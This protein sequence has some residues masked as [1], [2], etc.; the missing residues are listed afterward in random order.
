MGWQPWH[1]CTC[2]PKP[3]KFNYANPI[4]RSQPKNPISASD[5]RLFWLFFVFLLF[6]FVLT[7]F[8]HCGSGGGNHE[9]LF[10]IGAKRKRM[11]SLWSHI[12]FA[13]VLL[14]KRKEIE[15]DRERRGRKGEIWN[16]DILLSLLY[17]LVALSKS[18]FLLVCCARTHRRHT[19]LALSWNYAQI[20]TVVQR[21]AIETVKAAK[22]QEEAARKEKAKE[23]EDDMT[24]RAKKIEAF[25][26][27]CCCCCCCW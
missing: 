2:A 10:C 11:P 16:G 27:Y 3:Q 17:L 8:T 13:V 25:V 5:L 12:N 20:I 18:F 9:L 15:A 23:K 7:H 21:P 24:N 6:V 26:Y 4:L 19:H 1:T 22:Q 14:M